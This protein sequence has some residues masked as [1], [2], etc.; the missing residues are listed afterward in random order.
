VSSFIY[1]HAFA[2]FIHLL[3]SD[4]YSGIQHGHYIRVYIAQ[5]RT[6]Q[7]YTIRKL[8]YI[9]FIRIEFIYFNANFKVKI[10]AEKF[11]T[12]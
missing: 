6:I 1:L 11:L 5:C 4:V 12:L 9:T 3:I 10:K 8:Y 2:I 7:Y